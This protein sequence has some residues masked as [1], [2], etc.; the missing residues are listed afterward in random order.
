MATRKIFDELMEGVAAMRAQ[1][2]GKNHIATAS[3]RE[4]TEDKGKCQ[5][6]IITH[7]ERG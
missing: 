6:I 7:I 3:L 2:E 5:P 4:S 1:R